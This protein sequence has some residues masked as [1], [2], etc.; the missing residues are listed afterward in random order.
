MLIYV[1]EL[2]PEAYKWP[3]HQKKYLKKII[4]IYDNLCAKLHGVTRQNLGWETHQNSPKQSK[5]EILL[6]SGTGLFPDY[7]RSI[8]IVGGLSLL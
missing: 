1:N 3:W 6:Q 8:L 5:A 7:R 2:D 4:I